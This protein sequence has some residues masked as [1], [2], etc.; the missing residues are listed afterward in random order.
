MEA[1]ER[2]AMPIR[3]ERDRTVNGDGG[4]GSVNGGVNGDANGDAKSEKEREREV[5][6]RFAEDVWGMWEVLEERGMRCENENSKERVGA[7]MI[8]RANSAM[9]RILALYVSHTSHT[10]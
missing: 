9:I 1:L 10:I 8:E 2:C 3:V 7:R 5:A 4:D 6:L